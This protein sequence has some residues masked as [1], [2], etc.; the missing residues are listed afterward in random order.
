MATCF[1]RLTAD[2]KTS[3]FISIIFVLAS[4]ESHHGVV[5][6]QDLVYVNQIPG[7]EQSVYFDFS[8]DQVGIL[9]QR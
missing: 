7:H 1:S 3:Y 9:P 5:F 4:G 6:I 8:G 2:L